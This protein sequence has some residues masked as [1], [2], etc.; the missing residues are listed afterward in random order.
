[1]NRICLDTSAYSNYKRGAEDAVR[2][3]RSAREVAVPAVVLGELRTGFRLGDRADRNEEE[4]QAFLA[5]PAIRVLDVDDPAATI[6]AD[7]LVDLRRQGT[8]LPTNDVWIA[9]LAVREGATVLTY[10]D[11]F[12]RIR[13]AGVHVLAAG[14]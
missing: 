8:P 3:I 12:R 14:E 2:V 13:R 11:H 1:M 6:Y 5:D 7:L 4:L 9:A 10:D